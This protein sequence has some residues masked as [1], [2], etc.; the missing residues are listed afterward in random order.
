MVD[1]GGRG[2]GWLRAWLEAFGFSRS[3][4]LCGVGSTNHPDLCD[5]PHQAGAS[6]GSRRPK[7]RPATTGH[8]TTTVNKNG[9]VV[10][11]VGNDVAA[12]FLVVFEFKQVLLF[13]GGQQQ[14]KGL[15]PVITLAE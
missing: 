12:G 7:A 4:S 13:H 9:S 2:C 5:R 15:K 10:G 1:R 6:E 8:P 14:S 3:P 11:V